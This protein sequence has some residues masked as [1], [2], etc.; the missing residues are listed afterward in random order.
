M[1]TFDDLQLA[2]GPGYR[3]DRELGGGGMSRVFLADDL[4]LRRQVVLK[5]LPSELAAMVH[6]ERFN[7]ETLLLAR[8][9]HPHIVPVLTATTPWL[10]KPRLLPI[11]EMPVPP[12]F[13]IKPVLIN[14]PTAPPL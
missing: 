12:L 7:R 8:L 4:A 11:V 1:S 9:Q 13:T 3:L 6:L 5:V 14:V 10:S 2:L